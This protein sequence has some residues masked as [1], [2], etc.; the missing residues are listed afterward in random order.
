MKR[1]IILIAVVVSLATSVA[2][3]LFSTKSN[4][5]ANNLA[6]SDATEVFEVGKIYNLSVSDAG[7]KVVIAC[8]VK[9]TKANWVSCDSKYKDSAGEAISRQ[10]WVNTN[11]VSVVRP[12]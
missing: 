11:N 8:T 3:S 7:D 4:P 12:N 1:H 6:A 5:A 10:L 9:A 2:C